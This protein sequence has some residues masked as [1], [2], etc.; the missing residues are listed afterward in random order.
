MLQVDGGKHTCKRVQNVC[1]VQ[2]PPEADLD[3]TEIQFHSSEVAERNRGHRLEV[4]RRVPF[5]IRGRPRQRFGNGFKDR[6]HFLDFLGK[7][8]LVDELA[9]DSD[10]LADVEK[11][12]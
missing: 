6:F 8:L 11:V 5:M 10:P 4:A 3:N 9:V 7:G 1:S 2:S 12:R